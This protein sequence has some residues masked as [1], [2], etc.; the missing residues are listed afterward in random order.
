MIAFMYTLG[1]FRK[2]QQPSVS[3]AAPHLKQALLGAVVH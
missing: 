1:V 3:P 2:L